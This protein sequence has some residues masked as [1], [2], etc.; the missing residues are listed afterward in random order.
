MI[1]ISQPRT[2]SFKDGT[3]EGVLLLIQSNE[4]TELWKLDKGARFGAYMNPIIISET[5]KINQGE[6]YWDRTLLILNSYSRGKY[7]NGGQKVLALPENFS[8]N[9]LEMI[10]SSVKSG[11]KVFIEFD[12]DYGDMP[13]D[14]DEMDLPWRAYVRYKIKLNASNHIAFRPVDTDRTINTPKFSTKEVFQLTIEAMRTT[15]EF[16][17]YSRELQEQIHK[18]WFNNAIKR[19]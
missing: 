19:I 15:D 10:R 18:E 8:T 14:E 17:N 2:Q 16:S 4:K 1:R 12:N 5:E 9:Q 7:P 3:I 13:E 6:I 11:D